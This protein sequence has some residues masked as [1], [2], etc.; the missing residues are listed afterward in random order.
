MHK[1]ISLA[2]WKV[3]VLLFLLLLDFIFSN[4]SANPFFS[5]SWQMS[6]RLLSHHPSTVK[7]APR[8]VPEVV[9]RDAIPW[10]EKSRTTLGHNSRSR[11]DGLRESKS[12]NTLVWGCFFL[13][14]REDDVCF[15][16]CACSRNWQEAVGWKLKEK[17][18][19][20]IR[21]HETK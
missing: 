1:A 16:K 21:C 10:S 17:K 2:S 11:T 13:G 3:L 6:L 14:W 12:I 19:A 4:A 20:L 5:P 8:T 7:M 18:A 15:C 9:I